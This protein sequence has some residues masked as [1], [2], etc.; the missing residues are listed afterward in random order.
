MK[1]DLLTQALINPALITSVQICSSSINLP[2]YIT[3]F[4][5]R[6][7]SIHT[8]IYYRQKYKYILSNSISFH[9]DLFKSLHVPIS[10]DFIL[11]AHNHVVNCGETE[12]QKS[13]AKLKARTTVSSGVA[14]FAGGRPGLSL[15]IAG[16]L[17]ENCGAAAHRS[18][19]QVNRFHSKLENRLKTEKPWIYHC[20]RVSALK[21]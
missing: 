3:K 15:L 1:F 21:K 16:I 7:D 11:R 13:S 17:C 5:P 12:Y 19:H 9:P 4:P 6:L 14:A 20:R 18:L 2:R 8:Y 10:N